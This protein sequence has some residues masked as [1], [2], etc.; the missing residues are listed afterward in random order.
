MTQ[1]GLTLLEDL[2]QGYGVISLGG[3]SED[4]NKHGHGTDL[5][6]GYVTQVYCAH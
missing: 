5:Q 6:E 3:L 1:H 4:T 2:R